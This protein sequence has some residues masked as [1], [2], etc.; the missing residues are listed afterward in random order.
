MGK[1][2]YKQWYKQQMISIIISGGFL[3][4]DYCSKVLQIIFLIKLKNNVLIMD[5]QYT[6]IR[7]LNKI[8]KDIL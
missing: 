6:V 3:I 1:C 8:L 2:D 5:L 7:I 4:W